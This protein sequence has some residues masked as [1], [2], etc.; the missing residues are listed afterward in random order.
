MEELLSALGRLSCQ[1][2]GLATQGILNN[3]L[4]PHAR[5]VWVVNIYIYIYIC[6]YTHIIV[7]GLL[8]SC[9]VVLFFFVGGIIIEPL[10]GYDTASHAVRC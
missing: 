8:F 6:V 2:Y 10:Q 5:P 7:F 3:D 1:R 9:D 4:D